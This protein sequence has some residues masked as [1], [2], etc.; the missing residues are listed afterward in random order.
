M[1]RASSPNGRG[2]GVASPGLDTDSLVSS[3]T[4]NHIVP[5]GCASVTEPRDVTADDWGA[6]RRAAQSPTVAYLEGR[7]RI[8][9][10]LRLPHHPELAAEA[11]AE[12]FGG[13]GA[14]RRWVAEVSEALR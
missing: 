8:L 13:R 5:E 7:Q 4:D 11:L 2:P 3:D 10:S 9:G 1:P 14:A 6:R 12:H